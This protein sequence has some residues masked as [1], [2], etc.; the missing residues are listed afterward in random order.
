MALA[1]TLIVGISSCS[2]DDDNKPNDPSSAFFAAKVDNL[3]FPKAEL[4][5]TVAKF[6]TSTKMLQIIGQ[7]ADQKEAIIL[8]MMPFGGKVSTAVDWK[9][10]TYDFDPIHVANLEYQASAEYN[11]WNGNGYDQWFTNWDYVKT[12]KIIISSNTGTHIKGTFSFDAVRKNSDGS[13]NSSSIK[14]VTEGTF[15]LDIKTL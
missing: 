14:K 15:D 10:G 1:I 4:Q 7:P 13:Y 12:D 5:F 11:K 8:T 9:P 6:V 3:S 2:K